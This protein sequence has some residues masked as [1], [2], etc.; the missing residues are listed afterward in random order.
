MTDQNGIQ[1]SPSCEGL[2]IR[3]KKVVFQKLALDGDSGI[4]KKIHLLAL[5]FAIAIMGIKNG[6]VRIKKRPV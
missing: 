1:K 6:Q 5:V 4:G 3:G 2:F